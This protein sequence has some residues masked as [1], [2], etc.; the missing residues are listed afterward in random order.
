ME[1]S[2]VVQSSG[3]RCCLCCPSMLQKLTLQ[4]KI[5]LGDAEF[6]ISS[7]DSDSDNSETDIDVAVRYIDI[8][9]YIVIVLYCQ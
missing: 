9:Y 4:L 6:I 5:A 2:S 8:Q 7:S 3:W 1:F